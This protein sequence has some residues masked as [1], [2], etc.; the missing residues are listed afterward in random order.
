MVASLKPLIWNG[1]PR[2][3]VSSVTAFAHDTFATI[4][5]DR[6]LR[7]CSFCLWRVPGVLDV[8]P[9]DI[10][11]FGSAWHAGYAR[12]G[13][14]RSDPLLAR[15]S[16]LIEPLDWRPLRKASSRHRELF[17]LVDSCAVGA[18]GITVPLRG[19]FGDV[20]LFSVTADPEAGDWPPVR[21]E[22][23][24]VLAGLHP[25]L[26]R[27]VLASVFGIS[28]SAQVRLTQRERQCLALAARGHTSQRI[29]EELGLSVNT[30]NS[31]IDSAVTRLGA[32]NRSHGVAKAVACGLVPPP[33]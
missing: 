28:V 29:A 5:A 17:A 7:H 27:R 12:A 25:T 14:R 2:E 18:E 21:A 23:V 4:L 3:P 32:S 6:A 33:A 26:H 1:R 22:I 9:Y 13:L 11:T 20:S 10:D 15:A 19:P 8:R 16:E 30:V 24:R 31:Y